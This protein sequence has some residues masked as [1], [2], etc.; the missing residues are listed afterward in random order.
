MSFE[1]GSRLEELIL[2]MYK[3]LWFYLKLC[4]NSII[5]LSR[6]TISMV[7]M[8]SMMTMMAVMTMVPVM[9]SVMMPVVAIVSS[10]MNNIDEALVARRLIGIVVMMP[11]I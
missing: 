10:L 8:M 5:Y 2:K 4:F 11:V 6:A 1:D 9:M 7:T 3:K